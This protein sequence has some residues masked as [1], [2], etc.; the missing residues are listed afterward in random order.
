MDNE[1]KQPT[2]SNPLEHIVM[3]ISVDDVL[4]SEP[5]KYDQKWVDVWADG[6]RFADVNFFDGGFHN[7][8]E[9]YQGDFEG[10]VKIDKVTHWMVV[11]PPS[12]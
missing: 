11:K 12:T 4:P 8:L 2:V 9:D 3:W 6:E 10:H 5:K 1:T 7:I